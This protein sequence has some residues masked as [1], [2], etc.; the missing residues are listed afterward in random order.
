[1]DKI[2]ILTKRALGV[3]N[4]YAEKETLSC[5]EIDAL[6]L[7]MEVIRYIESLTG[8]MLIVKEKEI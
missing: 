4:W 8:E 3:Y 5:G 2:P 7:S 1:M 6:L